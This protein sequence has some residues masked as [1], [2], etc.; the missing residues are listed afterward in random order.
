MWDMGKYR[1]SHTLH[2][3]SIPLQHQWGKEIL[4]SIIDKASASFETENN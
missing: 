3:L 4:H 1:Y 2:G